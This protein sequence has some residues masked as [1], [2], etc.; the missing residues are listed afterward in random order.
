MSTF[1]K[2]VQL[3]STVTVGASGGSDSVLV[4]LVQS[5]TPFRNLSLTIIPVEDPSPY[6]VDVYHD[7]E[8]E[9]SHSF[10]ATADRV[11]CH[12]YFKGFMFPANTGTNAIP[13]FIDPDKL[14]FPGLGIMIQITNLSGNVRVFKAYAVFEQFGDNAAFAVVSQE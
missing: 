10:T 12:M 9:E 6:T 8:L 5:N 14:D 13:R 3:V 4:D 11:V 7:G 1:T 2:G